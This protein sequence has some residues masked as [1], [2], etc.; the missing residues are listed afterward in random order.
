[1]RYFRGDRPVG[2]VSVAG[3]TTAA[4]GA[5]FVGRRFPGR[6]FAG[7]DIVEQQAD[8][9]F[10]GFQRFMTNQWGERFAEIGARR[11]GFWKDTF[12]LP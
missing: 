9:V 10:D 3:T 2:G 4:D 11:Q 8:V 12:E 7:R 6:L 1:M 5:L